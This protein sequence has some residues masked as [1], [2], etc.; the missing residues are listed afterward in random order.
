[1]SKYKLFLGDCLEQMKKIPDGMI[2]LACVDPPYFSTNIKVLGDSQW[3]T[4]EDYIEWLKKLLSLLL[5]KLKENGAIYIFHNDL[6][7]M[8]DILYWLKHDKNCTLRNHIKWNKFPTHNN[9]SRVVKTYG[10]NRNYGQTFSEDIY[11]ITKQN[12]YFETPFAKIMK[13]EMQKQNISQIDISKLC[14]SKSGKITGWVSNKL[15]GTQIPTKEQWSKICKLFKIK[16]TYDVILEEYNSVRY[17]FN[18]PYINFQTTI[19][20]QKELLKPYSEIWEY[21]KDKVDG[22]YTSKPVKMMENIIKIS[23]NEHDVVLD[24]TMGSGST[25]VACKNLNRKFIGIEKDEK[26]F[27]LAKERIERAKI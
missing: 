25:G 26:Y 14:L 27:N 8:T 12:D 24:A 3:K 20:K 15:K 18:Q 10:K 22:F 1:M 23:T 11:F 4:L 9:F 17:K 21:E 7:I 2:D 16:D 13:S 5:N 6:S 19:E